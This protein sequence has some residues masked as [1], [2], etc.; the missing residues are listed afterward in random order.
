[1]AGTVPTITPGSITSV[2]GIENRP[3]Y[4]LTLAPSLVEN[5]VVK[6]EA[7]GANLAH[8]G[9]ADAMVSV[10]WGSKLMKNVNNDQ[11][12]TKIMT[13]A[14]VNEFKVYAR[15]HLVQGTRPHTNVSPAGQAYNWVKM[16]KVGNL[17]DGE[18]YTETP[19]IGPNGRTGTAVVP[20]DVRRNIIKFSDD[21]VWSDLGKVLAVDIFNGNDDRFDASDGS[22]VNKGNV[23]F[24]AGG[25]T[26]VIGLDTFDPNGAKSNLNVM[27]QFDELQILINANR[28][29]TFAEACATSVGEE[30]ARGLRFANAQSVTVNMQ[31]PDGPVVTSFSLTELKVL[32][33]PYAPLLEAGIA[34]GALQLKQYLQ[35]KV[36]QYRGWQRA[37]PHAMQPLPPVPGQWRRAVPHAVQPMPPLP[38]VPGKTVP[39]GVLDRMAAIGWTVA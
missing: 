15:A 7:A 31:G 27:G 12:N 13:P 36:R 11:V 37:V 25:Q 23:M 10:K 33:L 17:S 9:D 19:A 39:Q 1:M 32:F 22:W 2:R 3:V 16:P 35:N 14:E 6:G 29:H 24:L 20:A 21:A 26:A 8:M 18:F 34:A 28:R 30:L 5:L 4:F 38:Q